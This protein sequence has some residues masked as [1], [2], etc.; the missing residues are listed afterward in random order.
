MS[1]RP[2]GIITGGGLT[3]QFQARGSVVSTE[4]EKQP[5]TTP[6]ISIPQGIGIGGLISIG[7]IAF[8]LLKK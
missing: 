2:I 8:L 3:G 4:Q 6:N 7:I 1:E 5:I